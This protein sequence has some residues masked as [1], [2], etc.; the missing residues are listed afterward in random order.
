M[1]KAAEKCGF[2]LTTPMGHFV[3]LDL[4]GTRVNFE[5]RVVLAPG[6]AI[7]HHI[8]ITDSRGIRIILGQTYL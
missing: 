3:G 5:N 2:K 8:L 6:M 4:T 7:V 1:A